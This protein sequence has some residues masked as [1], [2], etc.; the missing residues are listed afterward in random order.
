MNPKPEPINL[1]FSGNPADMIPYKNRWG[2][3][4]FREKTQAADMSWPGFK[5]SKGWHPVLKNEKWEW[6]EDEP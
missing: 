3:W 5:N 4:V 6:E 2:Q 1:F